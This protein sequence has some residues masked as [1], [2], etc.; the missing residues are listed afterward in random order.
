MI[1]K[2]FENSIVEV[3]NDKKE[4]VRFGGNEDSKIKIWKKRVEAPQHSA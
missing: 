2:S 3:F 4:P 1:L